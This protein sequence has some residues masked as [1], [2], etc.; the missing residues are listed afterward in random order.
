[1]KKLILA[2]ASPR[3]IEILN[4]LGISFKAVTSCFEELE[5]KKGQSPSEYVAMNSRGKALDVAAKF[6]KAIVV[7]SDT[8]VVY[9]NRVL[10]KPENMKE[11]FEYIHLLSGR[12]HS[13]FTGM[14]LVDC[15]TKR[16][17]SSCEQTRVTFRELTEKEISFYLN[18]IDP[19]DKAGA[20]AIQGAGSLIVE[21]ISGCY[22]NVVGL[23]VAK[24]ENMLL[25]FGTSLFEYME[26]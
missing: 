3:R 4:E 23:P 9:R 24:L 13:V 22:Y 18:S 16:S 20:Y 12:T 25:D 17:V 26:T 11:A 2:T 10:G 19:M 14:S 7:G 21:K 5:C 6:K 1:M 8:V 15:E